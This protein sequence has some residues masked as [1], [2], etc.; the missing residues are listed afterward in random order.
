MPPNRTTPSFTTSIEQGIPLSSHG[1]KH[2]PSLR[3]GGACLG[4]R[5]RKLKCDGLR[6]VCS[7]CARS[8]KSHGENPDSVE[9]NYDKAARTHA[10]KSTLATN[11]MVAKRIADLEAENA[12]LIQQL[13][14]ERT[15]L[16]QP[17]FPLSSIPTTVPTPTPN[18]IPPNS[19]W[20]DPPRFPSM[21]HPLTDPLLS[22]PPPLLPT[23]PLLELFYPGW[24]PTLP[25]PHL[26]TKLIDVFFTKPHPT[27]G[28]MNPGV[29]RAAL[30]LPP[31]NYWFPHEALVH[32]MLSQVGRMVSE[33]FFLQGGKYWGRTSET[34]EE[35]VVQYHM[36]KAAEGVHLAST[37]RPEKLFHVFQAVVL[38]TYQS[39]V[40]ASFLN[41]W[42]YSGLA[43]RLAT[44]LGL[45][46]IRDAEFC[47]GGVDVP[48]TFLME[49][50]GEEALLRERANM[51][52]F[53]VAC[54][55]LACA[56]TGWAPGLDDGD[57]TSLLP[58]P[59]WS[60]IPESSELLKSPLCP[61]NPQFLTSHPTQFVQPLQ[62]YFKAVVLLGRIVKFLQRCPP[63]IGQGHR[64]D[65]PGLQNA[66]NY[67]LIKT[68]HAETEA[69][70]LSIPSSYILSSDCTSD[71]AAS[72]LIM[73]DSLAHTCTIV[74]SE[75]FCSI[76]SHD[77]SLTTCI[78]SARS[79]LNGIHRLLNSS[80]EIP[81]LA[82]AITYCWAVCGRTLVRELATKTDNFSKNKIRSEV[83]TVIRAMRA[84]KSGLGDSTAEAL[85]LLLSNP[86]LCSPIH[87]IRKAATGVGF[88]EGEDILH[89]N[90]RDKKTR[91][92]AN[93]QE[94]PTPSN[95]N[96]NSGGSPANSNGQSVSPPPGLAPAGDGEQ[97]FS[98][99]VW[100][101]D[102]EF[103]NLLFGNQEVGFDLG[104]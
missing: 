44:P 81:A 32:A 20:S 100:M 22:H 76:V 51:F 61:A 6:P 36:R 63:P 5:I 18:S 7:P 96:S 79:V 69:F 62:L 19:S 99:G 85:E 56:S 73:V 102:G 15:L 30:R 68:L 91:K 67:E 46:H 2:V 16:Q 29:F 71:S 89:K 98:A 66:R 40:D 59:R 25:Q 26:V 1:P 70:R 84:Y 75:P 24:P 33:D 4:C 41:A 45:N 35:T 90:S 65:P 13:E 94:I 17:T 43:M 31:T 103:Q 49:G 87:D 93:L 3:R 53:A 72:H 97:F 14:L 37:V 21:S 10:Q 101:E 48:E 88:S 42:G 74:L 12:R 104:S 82:P 95:S 8:A 55:K 60:G 92:N 27:S 64:E 83:E 34:R 28:M 52:W 80:F 9:C 11:D 50:G 77:F 78:Q 57:I 58:S 23:D 38:L 39:Y 54:D 47:L 86:S